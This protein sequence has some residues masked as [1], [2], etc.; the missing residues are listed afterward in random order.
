MLV[1]FFVKVGLKA[2]LGSKKSWLNSAENE[3]IK[4]HINN[5]SFFHLFIFI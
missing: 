3:Y 4:V 1:S 2:S 5:K